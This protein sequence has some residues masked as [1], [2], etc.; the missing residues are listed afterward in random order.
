MS[1]FF[2]K[3]TEKN[4]ISTIYKETAN[5]GH[6]LFFD[7]SYAL[8]INGNVLIKDENWEIIDFRLHPKSGKGHPI[9]II[10]WLFK[11]VKSLEER[12]IGYGVYNL[13]FLMKDTIGRIVPY[14]EEKYVVLIER[15]VKDA[16]FSEDP[17][18]LGFTRTI[19]PMETEKLN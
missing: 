6:Y 8:F 14:Y 11:F 5:D 15:H 16:T 13:D 1:Y 3:E 10:P 18:G 19:I 12:G 2:D 4:P 7:R 9:D 17:L